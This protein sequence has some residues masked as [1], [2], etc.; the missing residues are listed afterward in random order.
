ML[1]RVTLKQAPATHEIMKRLA[2]IGPTGVGKTTI[3]KLLAGRLGIPHISLDETRHELLKETDYDTAYADE[4][5]RRDFEAVIAYWENYNPHVVRRT[6][7]L[8]PIGIFDFGAIHS[9]NAD[10]ERLA[11]IKR[12]LTDFDD[13]IFLLPC[14]NK[15]RS[16]EILIERGREPGMSEETVAMWRRIIGRFISDGSNYHL[17]TRMV[18]TESKSPDAVCEAIASVRMS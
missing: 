7:E 14:P 15:R 12:L 16:L 11:T 18:F 13:V 6:L 5:K 9:V 8:Y 1:G 4:L 3:A 2:L 10:K 17:C